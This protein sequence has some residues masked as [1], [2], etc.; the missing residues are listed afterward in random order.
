MMNKTNREQAKARAQA[1]REA[2][3]RQQNRANE[4]NWDEQ[5]ARLRIILGLDQHPQCQ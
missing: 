2:H 1:A 4:I 5:I 3:Q